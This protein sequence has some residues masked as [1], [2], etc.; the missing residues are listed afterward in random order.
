MKWIE[1][2]GPDHLMTA[3]DGAKWLATFTAVSNCPWKVFDHD[4]RGYP[5]YGATPDEAL[6]DWA[7]NNRHYAA[8]LLD[9]TDAADHA[10]RH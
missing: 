5:G 4:A 9:L 1:L 8:I 2:D 6:A 3:V 7:H 10:A